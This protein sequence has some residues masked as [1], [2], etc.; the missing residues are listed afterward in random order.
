MSKNKF[1]EILSAT[2]RTGIDK[3]LSK[4]EEKGF[5]EAP[6]STKFHL[7]CKGGLL[8]HSLNVY[9]AAMFLREQVIARKPELEA[10]L[11]ADSVAICALL[12]DTCKSDIYKEGIL[13][14]KNAD[15]YWEKYLGYLDRYTCVVIGHKWN[16]GKITRQPTCKV[17]GVK[18]FTCTV[19]GTKKTEDIAYAPHT[20]TKTP[21]VNATCTVNGNIEYYTCSVCSKLFSDANGTHEIS[22]GDTVIV[23]Q[24]HRSEVVPGTPAWAFL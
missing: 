22:I 1:T 5:F 18:E 8:E 12:H 15:G 3:V 11:P 4:L 9:E 23:A 13:N 16:T 17:K 14:R 6:A 7:S 2:G 21:K 10:Q 20:L 24:G 19:C